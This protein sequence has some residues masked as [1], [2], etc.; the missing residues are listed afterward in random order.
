MASLAKAS[1]VIVGF[2]HLVPLS[3]ADTEEEFLKC[4]FTSTSGNAD[5]IR[6]KKSVSGENTNL[7]HFKNQTSM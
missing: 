1:A 4:L 3:V 7:I 6:R 2:C 5:N